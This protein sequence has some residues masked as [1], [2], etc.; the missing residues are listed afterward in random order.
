MRETR[1]DPG[2]WGRPDMSTALG[3]RDIGSVYRLLQRHGVSQRRIA[4]M[5]GQSQ[6]E[7]SEILKGRRVVAYDVLLRIAEGLGVPRGFMGLAHDDLVPE[8]DPPPRPM[9]DAASG[10]WVVRLPV[11]VD[12][13]SAAIGLCES[14]TAPP[15][16]SP[17]PAPAVPR[18]EVAQ[19]IGDSK[20]GV[21]SSRSSD[22]A[23]RRWHVAA[24]SVLRARQPVR[25]WVRAG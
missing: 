23:P 24:R 25:S 8:A 18:P 3:S 20:S 22:A 11:F 7:I 15:V 17:P 6:S 14:L 5:T 13:Y 16:A 9:M 19:E 1:I 2:I 10:R 4:A 21:A 12:S